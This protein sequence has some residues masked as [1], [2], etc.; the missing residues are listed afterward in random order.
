MPARAF[1]RAAMRC[2][3][4]PGGRAMQPK[5][6]ERDARMRALADQLPAVVWSTDTDL[7]FTSSSGGGLVALGLTRDQ[8][9][10]TTLYEFFQTTDPEMPAIRAHM[11]AL[12][13]ESVKYETEFS[14]RIYENNV[15]PFRDANGTVVGAVGMA[16]DVTMRE[17]ALAARGML[18]D[19]LREQ[20]RLESIGKLAS[21][22]A[23]EINNPLQSILNFAQ[24][25]RA[26]AGAGPIREY[27]EE[28]A[29]EVRRLSDIMRNLQSLVHQEGQLPTEIS[30]SDLVERTLSLFRAAL[31]KESIEVEL[32]V[33]R[34]L[35]VAWARANGVQQV[36]INLLTGA[37]DALNAR[38]PLHHA[39][40]RMRV[41]AQVIA[42]ASTRR[43]RLTVEDYG[44]PIPAEHIA[45]V[46]EPFSMVGGRDQ[47][48]GLRLAISHGIARENSGVLSVES[49][50]ARS[51]RFHLDLPIA[52]EQ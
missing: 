4:A 33:P 22:L 43:V 34:D 12:A 26:R 1:P 44:A 39:E 3:M 52:S 2:I 10:G 38:Y 37:R 48:T 20:F 40:K 16:L 7:R 42:V 28:I 17:N 46:F 49:D 14:G 9:V 25:I 5:E 15:E 24:L 19:K 47:G 8:V 35:P 51:T 29:H 30:L 31:R 23:H 6:T 41:S 27:S 36:L 13:G 21:G 11:R 32:D 18:Q 50:P 45:R